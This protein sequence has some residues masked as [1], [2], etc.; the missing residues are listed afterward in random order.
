MPEVRETYD[1]SENDELH[2]G[3]DIPPGGDA[4]IIGTDDMY[5]RRRK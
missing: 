3:G 1:V 4:E 2:P 5:R